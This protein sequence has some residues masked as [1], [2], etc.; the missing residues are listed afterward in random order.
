MVSKVSGWEWVTM[1][2][3]SK[4]SKEGDP[5]WTTENVD[6]MSQ[7]LQIWW[8]LGLRSVSKTALCDVS[9]STKANK[10]EQA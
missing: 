1:T 5:G 2:T 3:H 7:I 4:G 8:L 10:L 9:L 6:W